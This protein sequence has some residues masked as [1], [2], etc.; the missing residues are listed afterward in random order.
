MKKIFSKKTVRLLVLL[1][2]AAALSVLL[3]IVKTKEYSKGDTP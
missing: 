2:V 3:N 1:A